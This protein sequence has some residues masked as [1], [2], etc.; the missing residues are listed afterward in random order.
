MSFGEN[1][2]RERELRGIELR[3]IAEATKISLRFLQALEQDRPEVL[4][5]G[6]FP[7][8]FVRQYARHLGLDPERVAVEFEHQARIVAAEQAPRPGPPVPSAARAAWPWILAGGGLVVAAVGFLLAQRGRSLPASPPEST[9][10]AAASGPAP[11]SFPS[12]RVYPPPAP[13][14][15]EPAAADGLVL[16]LEAKERCWVAVQVDGVKQIDRVLQQGETERVQAEKEIVL[17]VGNA[18]GLGFSLNGRPGASLGRPGEVRRN[19]VINRESLPA[20]VS[21]SPALPPRS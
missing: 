21:A 2:R 13:G 14:A 10:V 7:K 8:A 4:P 3:E 5:G 6:I 18:G 1:L 12:D 16:D 17:H 11:L 15:A 9:P 20:L 19:V